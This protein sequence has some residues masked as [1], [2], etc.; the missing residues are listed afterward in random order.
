MSFLISIAGPSGVGKTTI[1]NMILSIN[2]PNNSLIISG[3]DAH[4]WERASEYWQS[5]THL[6]P[7]ANNL[8]QDY[9]QLLALKSGETIN[10]RH[11]NH[12]NGRFDE[13]E[14]ITPKE[15]II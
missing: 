3:D 2:Q 12:S 15:V 5:F 10:R 1:A 7:E 4:K 14:V 11:Y 8:E 6:D 13:P 9:L